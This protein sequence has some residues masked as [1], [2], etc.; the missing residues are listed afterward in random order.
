MRRRT[1]TIGCAAALT[2]AALQV[3]TAPAQAQETLTLGLPAIP[4]VF[5]TVQAYVAQQ[6]KLFEKH[7]VKGTPRYAPGAGFSFATM[8]GNFQLSA[9]SPG[10][11]KGEVIPNF[12]DVFNGSAPDVGAHEAAAPSMVFG[13][14]AQFNPPAAARD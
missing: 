11:D 6:E 12:C 4:P 3:A 10:L 7:G 13:V 8:T 1:F 9:D 2:A 5:V 14:K